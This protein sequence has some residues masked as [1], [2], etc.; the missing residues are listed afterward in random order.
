MRNAEYDPKEKIAACE[1]VQT[2]EDLADGFDHK[3]P[4][5]QVYA[6]DGVTL[7]SNDTLIYPC[8]SIAKF[9]FDD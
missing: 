4:N 8:G 2:A 6:V 9:I 5:G 7:L 3:F 1:P